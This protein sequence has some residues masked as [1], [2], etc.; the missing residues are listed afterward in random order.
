MKKL[1]ELRIRSLLFDH[2]V[3]CGRKL[4]LSSKL[5][6]GVLEIEVVDFDG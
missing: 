5:W 3:G 2:I 1:K 4:E 6:C